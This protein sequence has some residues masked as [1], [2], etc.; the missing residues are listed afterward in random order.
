MGD[1]EKAKREIR[2]AR[3]AADDRRWDLL[4]ARILECRFELRPLFR[5]QVAHAQPLDRHLRRVGFFFRRRHGYSSHLLSLS[6]SG[7]VSKIWEWP[8]LAHFSR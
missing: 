1:I 2:Y 5:R 3:S 7:Y 4:D 6:C 8:Q